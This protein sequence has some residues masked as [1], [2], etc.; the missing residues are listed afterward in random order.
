VLQEAPGDGVPKPGAQLFPVLFSARTPTDGLP[1][2]EPLGYQVGG[3]VSAQLIPT[4]TQGNQTAAAQA[5]VVFSPTSVTKAVPRDGGYALS[6]ATTDPSRT[7]SVEVTPD[8]GSAIRVRATLSDDS[9][10]AGFSD[11][12][13]SPAGEAFHGFGGRH[14]AID[15]RGQNFYNWLDQEDVGAGELQPGANPTVGDTYLFPSGALAAYYVQSSFVSN[16]GYGFLLNQ[17]ELS[18]WRLASD[19]PDAWQVDVAAPALDYVVA[20]GGMRRAAATLTARTGRQPVPPRWA[21][22]PMLDR[23]VAYPS[24]TAA[25]YQQQVEQDLRDIAR[26]HLPLTAYRIEGWQFVDRAWLRGVIHKLRARGIHPLVYFRAFVGKDTIGTDDPA[27][28]DVATKNGYVATNAAGQPY[29]FVSNFNQPSALIDFTNPAAVS[30]WQGRIRAALALGADG[31]M[32]DFGEQTLPDMHFKDGSTGAQMHNRY[33]IVY[34]QAT[35]AAVQQF[36]RSR[37]RRHIFFFTRAGYTGSPGTAAYENANFPGDETTDWTR[38]SGLASLAPDMLN[39]GIGG[40]FG[41]GTDIGGYLD[42][43]PYK[44]TTKELFIRWA[45]WAALTP[46]FRLHGSVSAG[47]HTPWTFDQQT[48]AIYNRLSRLH[49][50]ARPLIMRLWKR[51]RRTGV[52]IARP[53]YLSYPGDSRAA[54]QDQEW[55]LGDDVLVAPVVQQGATS[56]DVYFPRGCWRD[57]VSRRRMTGPASRSVAAPLGRLPFFVRCGR[58]PFSASSSP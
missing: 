8:T 11:S 31:F 41:F 16:R 21:L 23:E 7:M 5:G 19:R 17:S 57:P 24:Q 29:T 49:M 3:A 58:R 42:V 13:L 25:S 36:E 32:L 1:V 12:F 50:R 33:P 18:H 53:L 22:G 26:Y 45:E 28:Y 4:E 52:P 14:N 38:S 39:R 10:V 48:V 9:G 30:W 6:V 40:A 27:Q 47:V 37:P 54:T 56:R 44:P 20:P 55:M 35:R 46:V 51:A 15:E 43:G 2:Y 34:Q